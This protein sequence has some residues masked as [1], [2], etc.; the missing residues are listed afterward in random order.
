MNEKQIDLDDLISDSN[1]LDNAIQALDIFVFERFSSSDSITVNDISA[2][3]GFT[4]ALCALSEKNNKK[5]EAFERG[6]D[7]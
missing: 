5:I 7:N 3:S 1:N 2:L 6:V 4:S